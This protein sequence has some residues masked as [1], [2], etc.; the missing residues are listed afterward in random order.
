MRISSF[1]VSLS[2]LTILSIPAFAQAPSAV[3]PASAKIPT[4]ILEGLHQLAMGKP[5]EA[6]QA[7]AIGTPAARE[8]NANALH[9]VLDN[10]GA[11]QNFDVVNVQDLT[12]HLRVIYLALNFERRPNIARFLLYRTTNGWILIDHRFNIDD[13]IFETSVQP[14]GQ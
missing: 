7:W 11:Y 6:E 14:A 5:E 12:P 3:E 9:L 10:S 2:L 1:V 8:P 13:R 4:F